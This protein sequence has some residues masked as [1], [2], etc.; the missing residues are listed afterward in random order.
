MFPFYWIGQKFIANTYY[1]KVSF[2]LLKN[3]KKRFIRAALEA[4]TC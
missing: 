3:D 1:K 4:E 2:H